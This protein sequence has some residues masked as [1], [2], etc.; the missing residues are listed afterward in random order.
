MGEEASSQG[1]VELRGIPTITAK[2]MASPNSSRVR[3]PDLSTLNGRRTCPARSD[4]SDHQPLA[5]VNPPPATV[6]DAGQTSIGEACNPKLSGRRH[7]LDLRKSIRMATWNV[8]TLAKD[9][10]REA[11]ARELARLDIDVAC[12]TEARLTNSGKET[13]EGHMFLH[14][15]GTQRHHGVCLI[16]SH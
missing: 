13:V 7:Q 11:M 9:G 8:L 5:L 1:V 3:A 4:S 15:G 6:T 12:L 14:S 16:L 10:Y 2:K